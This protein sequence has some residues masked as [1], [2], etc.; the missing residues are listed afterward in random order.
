[1]D[2]AAF[3]GA[4]NS[5]WDGCPPAAHLL[6]RRFP[7]RWLRFHTLPESKRYATSEAEHAE[8]LRR[9]HLLLA[10][11]LGGIAPSTQALVAI[12]CSW[13]ATSQPTARDVAVAATTPGA[14]HWRSDD[15]ATDPGF[16]SW[17]HHY[18]S[19][20]SLDDLALDDLLL[21][22]ADDMTDG[23]I[24]TNTTCGWAFHPYD[25]GVDVFA[26]SLQDRNRLAAAYA[27]WLPAP[28]KT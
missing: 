16:H 2:I 11:L 28:P 25:G 12:T 23:V 22:V 10:A 9:H 4:W 24:M 6:R 21:C 3:G 14:V 19:E 18:V 1:V 5:S 20:T 17:Q 15:L 7:G 26:G 13:S 27:Q 8:I